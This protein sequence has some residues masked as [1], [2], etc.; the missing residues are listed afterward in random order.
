[1]F[2]SKKDS[3][4]NRQMVSPCLKTSLAGGEGV[5]FLLPED[6]RLKS[7]SVYL[8][9]H[10]FFALGMSMGSYIRVIKWPSDNRN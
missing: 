1:M 6:G 7:M 8:D 9:R 5:S 4:V 10:S 3:L 2:I